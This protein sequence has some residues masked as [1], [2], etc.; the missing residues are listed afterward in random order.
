MLLLAGNGKEAR[1]VFE[2]ALALADS[3]QLGQAIGNVARAIRTEHGCIG[4]AN[5]YILEQ[6]QN[7]E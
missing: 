5:A 4:P 6:R 2:E 3:K 7:P 1:D